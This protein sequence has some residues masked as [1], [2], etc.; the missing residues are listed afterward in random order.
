[1]RQIEIKRKI[2]LKRRVNI[3]ILCKSQ[4]KENFN[5]VP[6]LCLLTN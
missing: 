1:M 2:L 3:G 4:I 6:L 5:K